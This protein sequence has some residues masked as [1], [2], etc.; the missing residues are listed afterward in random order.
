MSGR[1][2]ETYDLE[3]AI[4]LNCQRK[5]CYLDTGHHNSCPLLKKE[6]IRIKEERRNNNEN[7]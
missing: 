6:K 1:R 2:S 5:K 4:C 7:V 3:T